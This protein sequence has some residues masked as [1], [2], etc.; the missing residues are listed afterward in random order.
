ME[1]QGSA[2]PAQL[3]DQ[4]ISVIEENIIKQELMKSKVMGKPIRII[5]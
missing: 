2:K 3:L 5:C 1:A 4:I